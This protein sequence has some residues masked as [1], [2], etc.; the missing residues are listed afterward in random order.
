[1]ERSHGR[2]LEAMSRAPVKKLPARPGVSSPSVPVADRGGEKVNVGFSDF[3]AGSGNQLRDP[4]ARRRAGGNLSCVIFGS[5][6]CAANRLRRVADSNAHA[7]VE[8]ESTSDNV[9]ANHRYPHD[10]LQ[11]GRAVGLTL[12]AARHRAEAF[13]DDLAPSTAALDERVNPLQVGG[14]DGRMSLRRDGLTRRKTLQLIG[15]GHEAQLRP[16]KTARKHPDRGSARIE[17]LIACRR[18]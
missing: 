12:C 3:G 14:V 8:H 5:V 7:Q 9:D 2:E 1:M 4:R 18:L 15:S 11:L 16:L 17:Q 13:E 6:F 10:A